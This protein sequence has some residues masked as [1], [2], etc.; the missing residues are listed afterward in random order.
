MR[1]IEL[2]RNKAKQAPLPQRE[3]ERDPARP[4]PGSTASRAHGTDPVDAVASPVTPGSFI[5]AC[6][7]IGK[8]MTS[9]GKNPASRHFGW[10]DLK[11]VERLPHCA[12][13]STV[14]VNTIVGT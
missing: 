10:R 4:S 14:G 7:R 1:G 2:H 8:P 11:M 9:L 5:V 3:R 12:I 13:D 6:R